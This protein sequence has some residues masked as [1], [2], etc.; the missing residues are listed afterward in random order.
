MLTSMGVGGIIAVIILLFSIV[1]FS[2]WAAAEKSIGMEHY[3]GY[4]E[5]GMAANDFFQEVKTAFQD[6]FH[7]PFDH[8]CPNYYFARIYDEDP[9]FILVIDLGNHSAAAVINEFQFTPADD[10]IRFADERTNRTLNWVAGKKFY[11]Y[12]SGRW[13]MVSETERNNL[14]D[15]LADWGMDGEINPEHAYMLSYPDAETAARTEL[16]LC[17]IAAKEL[18]LEAAKKAGI[19]LKFK[20]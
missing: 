6:Y 10:K 8:G 5:Y 17:R 16:T 4:Q 3:K 19:S 20:E 18:A 9:R 7:Y 15:L 13:E 14:L 1:V 2:R 11:V 12:R